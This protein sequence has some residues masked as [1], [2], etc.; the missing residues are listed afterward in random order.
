MVT[1][2]QVISRLGLI[3]VDIETMKTEVKE[4]IEAIKANKYSGQALADI[5]DGDHII[6]KIDEQFEHLGDDEEKWEKK[7]GEE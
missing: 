5:Y 2:E 3:L 4:H 1:N 7:F 6:F